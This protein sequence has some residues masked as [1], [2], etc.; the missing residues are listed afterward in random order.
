MICTLIEGRPV[1]LKEVFEMLQRNRRQHRMARE[2][3]VDY[4]VRQMN[5]RGS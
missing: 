1:S 4:I 2:R 5:D 3:R